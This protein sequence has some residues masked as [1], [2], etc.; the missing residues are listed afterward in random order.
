MNNE[1]IVIDHDDGRA[2]AVSGPARLD[3]HPAAV[4]LASLSAG[5]RPTMRRALATIAGILAGA[6]RADPLAIPWQAL[7]FQHTAAVRAALAERYAHSTANRMIC[8]LRGVLKAAWR[9]GLMSA[10]DYRRA[11]DIESVRGE[12]VPAGRAVSSGELAALLNSCDQ[13]AAGI[14]DAA[15]ISALYAGGLRRAELVGLDAA[16][17]GRTDTGTVLHVRAGKG[18]KARRVPLAGGAAAALDDWLAVRGDGPGPLFTALGNR[19]RGGRLTTQGC[20]VMI[21]TRATAAG[22]PALSPHD[23]RRSF[24]SDLLD[25]G[26]DVVTVQK[27]AGH[28][29]PATTARYDRRDERSKAAAVQ[30]LHVPYARRALVD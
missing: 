18:N 23:L 11:A 16:D 8:A 5:S 13:S 29:D 19:N 21:R 22:I 4:Y 15:I 1:L 10:E 6:D 26:A 2:L 27:L 9:L 17:V 20:Y 28:A 24:V 25:A 3:R 12:R 30:R 7:R 14:R